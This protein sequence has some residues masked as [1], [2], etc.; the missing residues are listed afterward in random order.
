MPSSSLHPRAS[1]PKLGAFGVG[2]FIRRDG[3]HPFFCIV[4]EGNQQEPIL[5]GIT[6]G[7]THLRVLKKSDFPIANQ[8]EDNGWVDTTTM[9]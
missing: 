1:V 9:I 3:R 6:K 8:H 2:Q 5:G 7:H 4:L